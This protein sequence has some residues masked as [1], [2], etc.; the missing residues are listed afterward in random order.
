VPSNASRYAE[1]ATDGFVVGR[2][3]D[4]LGR[5]IKQDPMQSGAGD[6]AEGY[7]YTMFSDFN[8]AIVQHYIE[9]STELKSDGTRN[10]NG[11]RVLVDPTSASGYSRWD[12]LDSTL[13]PVTPSTSSGGLY[14]LDG[15][16]PTQRNVP[17]HTIILTISLESIQDTFTE[18]SGETHLSYQD[19][20]TYNTNLTQIYPPLSYIGNL[21]RVIDPKDAT[22]LASI[23]PD[24]SE[25]R[26]YCQNSGCDYTLKA[27][28]TDNSEYFVV[29]HG[30]FRGWFSKELKSAAGN[31]NSGDS[32]K[33]FGVNVP[34]NKTIKKIELLETPEVW[35][36]LPASPK[37]IAS[38]LIN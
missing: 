5:C 23:V 30:G 28:Y 14:G 34:G 7:K 32:Y 11:G 36:G 38:R 29:L 9:G 26:W 8:A 33:V 20:I 15:G 18:V 2:Q 16:F 21:R 12:S 4:E 19:T 22:Q 10:Y 25:N 6:Q 24:T 3:F 17:V 37:V 31:P 35:K 27:T 1:C 13:V